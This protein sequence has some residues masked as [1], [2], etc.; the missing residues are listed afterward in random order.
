MPGQVEVTPLLSVVEMSEKRL[1]IDIKPPKGKRWKLPDK[2]EEE[3][4]EDYSPPSSAEIEVVHK[5]P[6]PDLH[7]ILK[8]RTASESSEE[9]SN[10]DPDSPRSEGEELSSSCSKKRSVSF[11]N[12]VDHASFK[13]SASVSSMTPA[14]KSKRRRQRK[15]E[16]K[17]KGRVRCNSEG[18]S[19]SEECLH[20]VSDSYSHSE[21]EGESSNKKSKGGRKMTL[22]RAISDPGPNSGGLSAEND[23]EKGSGEPVKQENWKNT[24]LDSRVL[25]TNSKNSVELNNDEVCHMNGNETEK[26]LQN[27]DTVIEL[28]MQIDV[29]EERNEVNQINELLGKLGIDEKNTIDEDKKIIY[30]TKDRFVEE[31]NGVKKSGQNE[32]SDDDDYVDAISS[33]IEELKTNENT[34]NMEEEPCSKPKSEDKIGEINKHVDGNEPVRKFESTIHNDRSKSSGRGCDEHEKSDVETMLSWEEGEVSAEHVTTCGLQF[35][36][37]LIFDLDIE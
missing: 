17:R 18:T 1:T 3:D 25:Q 32:D 35:S 2:T 5:H 37:S 29:T 24:T 14:L 20:S 30:E 34:G 7:S 23:E 12:H 31:N 11:S 9:V 33:L 15:R 36:N 8:Q 27:K 6:P 13:S 16:E 10:C 19:S 28:K 22:R 26:D 21:E 4:D